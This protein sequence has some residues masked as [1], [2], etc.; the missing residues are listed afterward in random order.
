M[1]P[2]TEVKISWAVLIVSMLHLWLVTVV[3]TRII[4]LLCPEYGNIFIPSLSFHSCNNKC[5]NHVSCKCMIWCADAAVFFL[6]V[7]IFYITC[8]SNFHISP[9]RLTFLGLQSLPPER[10]K[11]AICPV[12]GGYIQPTKHLRSCDGFRVHLHLSMR[13]P[14]VP[15]G[16]HQQVDTAGLACTAGAQG[17]HTMPYPL[18]LVEL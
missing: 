7:N 8:L 18:G 9:D 10:R 13:S 14:T 12:I 6:H 4:F 5:Y 15:H 3:K 16:F 1:S 11:D 2:C 17:H